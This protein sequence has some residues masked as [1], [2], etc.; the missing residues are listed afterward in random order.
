MT[1]DEG[2]KG[3]G[4]GGGGG[5]GGTG[6]AASG[7]EWVQAESLWE[8]YTSSID[9]L[10]ERGDYI[11]DTLTQAMNDIDWDS[12]YQSAS[13]FGSGLASFLNGLISPELFGA[14][15][16]TIAGALNTA[17]HGLDSFGETFDWEDFGNSIA[18]GI[19]NFFATFDFALLADTLNKVGS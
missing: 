17:L 14:V 9:S 7:G 6:A 16:T 13:N 19:N 10:Y 1:S 18:T 4:G 5:A 15:G 2:S 12:V 11:G 8:K 3:S